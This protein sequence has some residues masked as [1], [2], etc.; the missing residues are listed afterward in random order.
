ME[1]VPS[2]DLAKY[3]KDDPETAK[4]EAP[5]VTRQLLEGLKILHGEAICHR[6]VKPQV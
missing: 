6:D 4:A 2:G 1:Y 5:E 3:M